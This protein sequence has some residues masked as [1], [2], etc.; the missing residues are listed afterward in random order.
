MGD[1][2]AESPSPKTGAASLASVIVT[3]IV[4]AT[5]LGVPAVSEA[6]TSTTNSWAPPAA[7]MD[8]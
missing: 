1:A 5:V 6:V 7:V 8:S 3:V 4:W 2:D